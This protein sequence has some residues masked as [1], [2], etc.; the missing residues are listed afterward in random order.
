MNTYGTGL[1][2]F[3][4][5]IQNAKPPEAVKDAFDDVTQA[6]EDE[7]RFKNEAEAY[8]NEVIPKARGAS[9]RMR[10]EAVKRIKTKLSLEQKVKRIVLPNL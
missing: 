1:T 9:A 4:V 6:R 10:E 7:E 3:K 5:N 2:I 8:R